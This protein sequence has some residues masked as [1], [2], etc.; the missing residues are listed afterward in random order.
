M[1]LTLTVFETDWTTTTDP[2]TVT[3]TGC[4]NNDWLFVIGGSGQTGGVSITAMTTTTT[5]GSTTAWSEPFESLNSPAAESWMS[6]AVAQ[7]TADGD[8][9]VQVDPTKASSPAWGFAAVQARGSSGLG[10]SAGTDSTAAKT[11]SLTTTGAGSAVFLVAI[12]NN[13]AAVG[14]AWTPTTD[15]TLIER[16]L[17][18]AAYT[19]HAAYW[20]NQSV[21]TTS[22][23]YTG[24]GVAAN[25]LIALEILVA[26]AGVGGQPRVHTVRH[27]YSFV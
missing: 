25:K 21:A 9:T 19:V 14:T 15:V 10:A 12:D 24:G 2:K 23:G 4:L 3:A 7:V 5:V 20:E 13:A 6:S 18:T 22:Y 16:Q 27:R 17:V 11:V 1:A 8:V 26:P